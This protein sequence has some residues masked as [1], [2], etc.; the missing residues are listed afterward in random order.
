M[1]QPTPIHQGL[2]PVETPK[3]LYSLR[4]IAIGTF[5][6]GPLAAGLLMRRNSINLG[7]AGQGFNALMISILIT[8]VAV[9]LAMIIPDNV[10]DN[11]IG[12]LLSAVYTLIIYFIAN[13]MH[14]EQLKKHADE[15]G[16]FYSRWRAFGI[17]MASGVVTLA[18][19]I[20][21]AFILDDSASYPNQE[22]VQN[23]LNRFMVNEQ[24]AINLLDFTATQNEYEAQNQVRRGINLWIKNIDITRNI[25]SMEGIPDEILELSQKLGD[26][27]QLRIQ[28]YNL[29]LKASSN[30]SNRYNVQLDLIN[31]QIEK[32]LAELE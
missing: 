7:N 12:S 27:C 19:I 25:Q 13:R 4:A 2:Q 32:L 26:Y 16:L 8:F 5:F 21:M 3:S 30:E 28:Q 20:V 22:Q 17:G 10:S 18:F 14:G 24:Q 15:E 1:N 23:E 31:I 11:T 6:G 9:S 29:I